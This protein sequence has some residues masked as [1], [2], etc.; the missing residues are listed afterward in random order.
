[1]LEALSL[2]ALW[3]VGAIGTTRFVCWL[4]DER[5]DWEMFF[6]AMLLWP[7]GLALA[8]AA[9]WRGDGT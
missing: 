7:V 5:W 3:C 2:I 1:M 4:A 8:L 6:Y 9:Y